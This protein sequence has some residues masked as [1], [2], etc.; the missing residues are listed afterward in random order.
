MLLR[1]NPAIADIAEGFRLWR[2]WTYKAFLI[3]KLRYIGTH[4]GLIW[5]VVSLLLVVAV[6]GS[7]WGVVLDK[8]NILSYLLYLITGFALWKFVSGAVGQG[9]RPISCLG[10]T[11]SVTVIIMERWTIILLALLNVLPFV[12]MSRLLVPNDYGHLVYLPL[13]LLSLVFWSIGVMLL[14]LV[15]STL[16]PDV[17]MM[18]ESLMRLAFLATPIIWEASRLGEYKSYLLYNPFFLPLES[19]RF[20][21]TGQTSMYEELSYTLLFSFSV[22][23]VGI[24]GFITQYSRLRARIV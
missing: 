14:V 11:S 5:P 23:M 18:V 21:I 17:R 22:F 4:L 1:A 16:F 10:G 12:L 9:N 19:M 15:L 20:V 8:T 13:G 3:Y 6:L 2:Y 7:I 24:I